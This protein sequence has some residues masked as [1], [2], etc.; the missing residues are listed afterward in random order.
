MFTVFFKGTGEY[1]IAILPEGQKVNSAY[2]IESVLRP[3]AEICCPQ[4][5]RT[6]ER[7]VMLHFDSALAHNTER[8]QENLASLGFRRMAHP[9]YSQDLVPCD[10]FSSV[11]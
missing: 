5:K 6:R 2:F 8:V 9:P 11:Q 3:L 7:R 4:G 1:R 10:F